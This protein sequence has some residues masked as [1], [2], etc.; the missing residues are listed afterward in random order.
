MPAFIARLLAVIL[1]FFRF[2][3]KWLVEL[4]WPYII[5]FLTWTGLLPLI[6]YVWAFIVFQLGNGVIQ[7]GIQATAVT[8]MLTAWGV[9]LFVVMNFSGLMA[10]RDLISTNPF[11]DV[12]ILSGS[13]YLASHAFPIRYVISLA[14]TYMIWRFTLIEAALLF[15][16]TI[17][18]IRSGVK[19]TQ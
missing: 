15:N 18:L 14:F 13:L 19:I 5:K 6:K 17:T 12:S 16:K 10:M 3:W 9:L 2:I 7:A 8:A 1:P 4:G 11:Q